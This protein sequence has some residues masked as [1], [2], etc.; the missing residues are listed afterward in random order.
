[1]VLQPSDIDTRITRARLQT[2][3]KTRHAQLA[4]APPAGA[5]AA[6][7]ICCVDFSPADEAA[8]LPFDLSAPPPLAIGT[9]GS[10]PSKLSEFNSVSASIAVTV[11][12]HRQTRRK[13]RTNHVNDL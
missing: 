2:A 5:A 8:P 6:P 11:R 4:E 12:E 7:L 3:L 13:N 9:G 1:M 10:G